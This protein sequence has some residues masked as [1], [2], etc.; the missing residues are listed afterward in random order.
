MVLRYLVLLRPF[1]ILMVETG[2]AKLVK[3]FTHELEQEEDDEELHLPRMRP[4]KVPE[5]VR[6]RLG[7]DKE[8]SIL[9]DVEVDAFQSSPEVTTQYSN[10]T[11]NKRMRVDSELSVYYRYDPAHHIEDPLAFWTQKLRSQ[12]VRFHNRQTGA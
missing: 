3:D 7:M 12:A 1:E 11:L 5:A 6:R 9:S 10:C 2:M 4:R 8:L